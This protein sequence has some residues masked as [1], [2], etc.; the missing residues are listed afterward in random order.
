M[1]RGFF[2]TGTDTGVG[3]TVVTGTIIKALHALNVKAAAMKPI[4]TG[5]RIIDNIPYPSDGMFLKETALM[6][7]DISRITPYCFETPAAPFVAS[8]IE[9][10]NIDIDFIKTRFDLLMDRYGKVVV[11]GI[12]GIMAPIR[13]NYFVSD[14]IKELALPVIV[15]CRPSLGTIN[16]TLLTINYALKEGIEIAGIIINFSRPEENTIAEQTNRSALEQLSPVA[17][18]GTLPYLKDLRPETLKETALKALNINLLLK[19]F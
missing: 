15:V 11:E 4:E 7:E 8:R 1:P 12:G 9:N 13:K 6:D 3:K 16:H 17:L 2:I 5:C 10:K 19:K 14:L 18:I